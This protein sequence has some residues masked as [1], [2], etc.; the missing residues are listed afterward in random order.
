MPVREPGVAVEGEEVVAA[1]V[2]VVGAEEA[3]VAEEEAP[4]T[5]TAME[6]VAPVW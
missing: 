1:P 4:G 2:M 3:A 5:G 6:A